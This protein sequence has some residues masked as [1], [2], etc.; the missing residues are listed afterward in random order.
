MGNNKSIV[1]QGVEIHLFTRSEEDYISL[2]DMVKAFSDGEMLIKSW[3]RNKDTIEFLGI[4]EEI[5]NPRFDI[6]AYYDI[7]D[8]SGLNRFAI[9]IKKWVES[10][11]AIGII[12]SAGR[13]GGTYARKEI[14]FEFATWLNPA[15]KI[16]VIKRL[17]STSDAN[18]EVLFDGLFSFKKAPSTLPC[19]A[20][21]MKDAITEF[22]K[23][24]ISRSP[25]YREKTLQAQ[26]PSVSLFL[27]KQF[28]SR[29]ECF[30]FESGLHKRYSKHR[31]R[32]EWFNFTPTAL[33]E[34][35]Q[36]F[37]L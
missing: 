24:G 28:A 6:A 13:Y 18:Y 14:A 36:I 33:Q 20:Y 32:G 17:L 8:E 31:V 5:N 22:Y 23:I 3:L 10:T 21:L 37:N 30:A 11:N 34:V 1:V 9:S 29:S 35:I 12:A 7:C 19:F 15:L 2:T 16:A 27:T 26:Q 25:A 4:W